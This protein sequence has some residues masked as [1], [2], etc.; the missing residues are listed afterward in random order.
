MRR[1]GG[2]GGKKGQTLLYNTPAQQPGNEHG[3]GC[4]QVH[5]LDA[6]TTVLAF[7]HFN[8]DSVPCDVRI[9]NSRG[10][11][12]DWTFARNAGAYKSRR[13]SVWVK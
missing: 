12:S 7:N 3:Y 4:L 2:D 1:D 6:K 8:S 10:D 13:L 5:D 11:H 9:G